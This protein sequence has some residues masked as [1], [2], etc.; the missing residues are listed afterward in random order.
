MFECLLI[1]YF[2]VLYSCW[3]CRKSRKIKDK[4]ERERKREKK[5]NINNLLG[6][7]W[8]E[9]PQDQFKFFIK[10]PQKFYPNFEW[11]SINSYEFHG[12]ECEWKILY[13]IRKRMRLV[14]LFKTQQ[15]S[16]SIKS[17][18]WCLFLHVKKTISTVVGI[19]CLVSS[20]SGLQS[21]I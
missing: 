16:Q 10:T 6:S 11:S 5:P 15:C 20:V 9:K 8:G 4:E 17:L 3:I 1:I 7:I 21:P 18:N 19:V 2:N 13:A 14:N 12:S